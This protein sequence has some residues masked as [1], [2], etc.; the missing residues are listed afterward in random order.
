MTSS[1]EI[2]L[3]P[4]IMIIVG[5]FLK[6]INFLKSTD[7]QVLNKIVINITL[8]SLIFINL[9]TASIEGE[10][11]LLPIT[12]VFLVIIT[13][14][15]AYAYSRFR[16]Y[17]KRLTWT[18]ILASSMMNTAFIGYPV[19]IGVLGN[20][21]FVMSIFYDM[22]MAVMFVVYAM[23]LVGVFGGNKKQVIHDG[24]TFTPLWAV[25]FA[26]AFNIFN[27]PLG[28][29]LETSL[30]YLS[31]ATIP[32]IMLSLALKLDFKNIKS[33]LSDTAFIL[34]LRLIL[35]PLLVMIIYRI[36]NIGSL[37]YDVAV[38]D[39]AM[40]IAMNC[41]VLSINYDLDSNLT[42]SVIFVSTLISVV[43]LTAFATFM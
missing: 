17:S 33:R 30:N 22:A 21:G 14:L 28:Y 32:L 25:V 7:S 41:L 5:L 37:I 15:I 6:H 23:I 8:P 12:A 29:V 18:I 11:I 36:L 9:S 40:P 10:V 27:I 16:S 13:A 43:S 38:L 39:S 34:S 19:I 3:V 1:F 31:Q 35:A 2:I 24:L 4:T 20:E 42:S 26:L